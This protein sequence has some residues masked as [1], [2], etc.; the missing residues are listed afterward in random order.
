METRPS[1][2]FVVLLT[3]AEEAFVREEAAR[4]DIDREAV[5]KALIRDEL[6]ERQRRYG[7]RPGVRV[8]PQP[9][10]A[11]ASYDALATHLVAAAI[12]RRR[13]AQARQQA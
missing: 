11:S 9:I 10:R 3:D 6:L 5:L 12:R 7:P 2:L 13:R 8:P 4:L 1:T